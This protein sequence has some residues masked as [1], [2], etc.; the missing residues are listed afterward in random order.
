MSDAMLRVSEVTA[1]DV[2]DLE[3]EA[4]GTITV[5]RSKTHQTGAGVVLPLRGVT[6]QRVRRWL[7]GA[8]VESG[9][10]FRG[11]K[12]GDKVQAGRIASRTVRRIVKRRVGQ[13]VQAGEMQAPARVSTHSFRV[14][15]AQSFAQAGA[16][17]VEM[18]VAGRW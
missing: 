16:G 13:A 17:L 14:G 1:L 5:R 15:S 7:Q 4:P 18:Q 10:L 2:S 12:C 6:V 11:V 3:A 9:P 8:G